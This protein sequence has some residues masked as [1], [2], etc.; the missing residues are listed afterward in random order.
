MAKKDPLKQLRDENP[1]NNEL[2]GRMMALQAEPDYVAAVVAASLLDHSLQQALLARFTPLS[3]SKQNAL[4][5][6]ASNGPLTSLAA[7]N[8]VAHAIGMYGPSTS[9]DL[10]SIRAIRNTFSHAKVAVTFATPAIADK[11]RK[12]ELLPRHYLPDT[13]SETSPKQLF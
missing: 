10:D 12:F 9:N 5:L 1:A 4:F 3:D 7:K 2:M 11:C 6:D 8:R 13:I